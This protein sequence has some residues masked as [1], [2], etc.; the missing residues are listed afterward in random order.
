MNFGL[1]IATA[2]ALAVS[3]VA[4][5]GQTSTAKP[6]VKKHTTTRRAKKPAAPSVAEQI[7]ALRQELQGQI[8][9][10][11]TDLADKDAQLRQAQQTAADAQAAAAKAEAAASAE[12]QAAGENA[13]A[14]NTLQ[15]SVTNLKANQA[16]VSD[17]TA[18]LKKEIHNPDFLRYKGVKLT[19]GGYGQFATIW[20]A[21]NANS[22]TS[23]NYGQYA[24]KNS[25]DYYQSEFRASG[26]ASRLSLKAQ[27]EAKGLKFLAYTE[28]DFLGNAAGNETQTNSFSPRL[29]L[30]FA[31]VDLPGGWSIAGGQNWSL[32]QTTRKGIDPLSEWLPSLIDNSYTPGF[33]YAREGT[34]RVVK[35]ITPKT[36]AGFSVENPDTVTTGACTSSSVCS[37]TLGNVQGL[38][39]SVDTV[40]PNSGYS[41]AISGANAING[42][43]STNPMPDLVAKF[44]FEPGW[45]HFEVK[46][47][48][49]AFRDRVYPNY[50]S[51]NTPVVATVWQPV[52]VGGVNVPAGCTMPTTAHPT[53]ANPCDVIATTTTTYSVSNSTAGAHNNTTYG[54]GIGVGAILP[55]V[56]NKVD[57]EFQ[58]LAGAGI[59]RFGTTSG[60]DVTYRPLI[61]NAAA[62]NLPYKADGAL[63]PV[64]AVQMVAGIETHP[65]PKF[66]FNLYGGGDYYQ[67]VS[68]LIP[69]TATFFG[70]NATN[71]GSTTT[72]SNAEAGYGYQFA[73]DSLC[74]VENSTTGLPTST[75][76]G[77]ST[78]STKC[79]G[80]TKTVWAIQ[81]QFWYRIFK[82]REGTVQFGASYAYVYREAWSGL[83]PNSTTKAANLPTVNGLVS[84]KTINQILMTSFRYYLP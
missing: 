11:K 9:G 51:P 16:S 55:L 73:S 53:P 34:I 3:F 7:Q 48:G 69:S 33:S 74:S 44:A 52:T 28:I 15:T 1:K 21:H 60:P 72:G 66:D 83:G 27:G 75:T 49:R 68:Y 36:W 42:N 25:P 22:D 70:G 47:I 67:R 13:A 61:N 4:C 31:N 10:L 23:D 24:F 17:E 81:P 32:L 50:L 62:L 71:N 77:L 38:A 84:P 6:T 43:P 18:K 78:T 46:A 12:Q 37:F 20:R 8:N 63:V 35:Q 40:S 82:G 58:G 39:N 54:G 2:S 59:G 14:V 41:N 26:R 65:T 57:F 5:Y 19:P 29:R 80:N 64:R 45:G 76:N 56:K 30:A 79:S